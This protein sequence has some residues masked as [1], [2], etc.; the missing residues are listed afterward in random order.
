LPHDRASGWK[1][2]V[3]Y[4]SAFVRS[5]E[6]PVVDRYIS[7]VT[8]F[9]R[10]AYHELLR[11]NGTTRFIS[12]DDPFSSI[13]DRYFDR[14]QTADSLN[15][16]LYVD[17]KTSLPDDLLLLTDKMSMASS[18]ECRA[19][20]MD[21]GLVELTSQMPSWLKVR[22]LTMKYLLK[23]A[24]APWLPDEILNRKKRG[25]GVPIGSWLRRDLNPLVEDL[26]SEG[27]VKKRGI[28]S[29][30]SIRSIMDRHKSQQADYTDQLFS[31]VNLELWCQIF[32]DGRN[33]R[34]VNTVGKAKS[35]L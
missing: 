31:L 5:A 8:L 30:P 11:G 20:F 18:L 12:E 17:L 15:R 21:Q 23:K 7:Y 29:W 27:Q 4:A 32:L 3:R 14:C 16:I 6:L 19:P 25:F 34:Q 35:V 28:F 13:L 22:G 26:L 9:S 24:V 10:E 1:N 33:W 2:A